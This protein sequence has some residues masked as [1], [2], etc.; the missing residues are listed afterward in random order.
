MGSAGFDPVRLAEGMGPDLEYRRIAGA[1]AQQA[2]EAIH[3]TELRD[4]SIF[5]ARIVAHQDQKHDEGSGALEP[6]NDFQRQQVDLHNSNL[7][8]AS[9]NEKESF[10]VPKSCYLRKC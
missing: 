4:F 5:G 7:L 10:A 2:K 8:V 9:D 3:E 1:P 6:E